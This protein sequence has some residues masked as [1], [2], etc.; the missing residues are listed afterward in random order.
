M[1]AINMF[2]LKSMPVTITLKIMNLEILP[3]TIIQ[4]YPGIS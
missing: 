4:S 2:K 3:T 1:S